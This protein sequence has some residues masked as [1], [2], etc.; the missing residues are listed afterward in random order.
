MDTLAHDLKHALRAL[1]LDWRVLVF[2]SLLSVVTGLLV[3]IAPALASS[4]PDLPAVMKDA[5]GPASGGGRRQTKT[6]S[7]LVTLEVALAVVLMIGAG[8]LIRTSIELNSVELGFSIDN[9][10]TLRGALPEQRSTATVAQTIEAVSARLRAIPGVE[11]AAPSLGLPL[12][13]RAGGPFDIVE[14]PNAGLPTGNAILVPTTG[15]YFQ[16]LRIPLLV[17]RSFEGSDVQ[18]APPVAVINQA[19]ADRYW[20]DGSNPLEDRV[21][22]GTG[23]PDAAEEPVRQIVGIVG[24][25]RQ[26][27]IVSDPAPTMYVPYAQLSDELNS[28]FP[29]TLDWIVRT[30]IEPA[31]LSA[32]VHNALREETRQQVTDIRVMRDTWLLSI[33]RQRLNLWLMTVFGA[34]ALLLGAVGVYGLVAY[35]VA[36]RTHEIG[37]RMAIGAH[38]SA[39]R[40][41]VVRQGM[42]RVAT[43]VTAG[44]FAAYFLANVLASTLFG[45]APH[46]LAIFAIVPL[47]LLIVGSAAV[48]VPALRATRVDPTTALRCS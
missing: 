20:S 40:N 33:S 27:G 43:G 15:D 3:G 1:G 25:I 47:L 6:L 34:V 42:A 4:R 28:A 39:V 10:L 38:A 45:V 31:A 46:D 14:R 35:S 18:A 5:G 30:S 19:M 17:G 32:V 36:K 41:M 48:Y 24:N 26:D 21:R 11:V 23:I 8:L 16:A 9:V 13:D 22:F 12:Q 29:P 37:I 2:T 44:T 7:L